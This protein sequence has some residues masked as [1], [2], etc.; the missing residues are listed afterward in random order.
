MNKRKI[1][2][3]GGTGFIGTSVGEHFYNKGWEVVVLSR[4]IKKHAQSCRYVLWNGLDLGTWCE[5]L[6]G[7]TA[8]LNL[9][10]KSV[11]CRYTKANK[12]KILKSRID[13]TK[14]IGEAIKNCKQPPKIW[15]NASSATIYDRSYFIPNGE[16][17][18]TGD[19]FS[20]N[21]CKKWEQA[22]FSFDGLQTR[23][24]VL[25]ITIVL[26]KQGE[27]YKKLSLLSK[28][29][30]GG[31]HGN[32]AQMFSW[33]HESDLCNA[34]EHIIEKNKSGAYNLAAPGPISNRTFMEAIRKHL[35]I[36]YWIDQP[37]WLLEIGAFLASTETE[38][39]LKSRFVIPK[40][41]AAQG[42]QFNYRN[43]QDCLS[44][45]NG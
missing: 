39:L 19:D 38:L 1:I 3:A 33:I 20:M 13:P 44:S 4:N 45:F 14:A 12:E 41:L 16:D 28:L 11:D 32:G 43:I 15:L 30:L 8:I 31:K 24:A 40:R 7:A 36:K 35:G 26:G 6:E 5:E 17:G 25:R 22:F 23:Q 9:C 27:A 34:I 21:I 29:F 2:I 42:F 37:K 10:G 18:I